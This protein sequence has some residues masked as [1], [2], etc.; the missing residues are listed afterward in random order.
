MAFTI[1]DY[2]NVSERAQELGLNIPTGLAVLPRNFE[3]VTSAIDLL[4]EREVQTVRSL[5]RQNNV[6]ET[7]LEK[8]NQKIPCIH[9]NE[10]ALMLPTIFVGALI[11]SQ[12]SHLLSL[13]LSII[14]NY[15]T[16]FFK[17][18]PGRRKV[19]LNIVVENKSKGGAKKIHYEGDPDGLKEITEIVGKVFNNDKLT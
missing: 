1:T 13:A 10:F 2:C 4:H 16:E 14:A 15:A 9:E 7:K 5:F 18:I 11:V 17:G 8:D 6:P 3:D 19:V 12:N